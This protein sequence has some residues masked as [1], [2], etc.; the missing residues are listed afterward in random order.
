MRTAVANIME[1][2]QLLSVAHTNLSAAIHQSVRDAREDM[3]EIIGRLDSFC[4]AIGDEI[5]SAVREAL[6]S[7][8][9]QPISD[10]LQSSGLAADKEDA[11]RKLKELQSDAE[12]VRREKAFAEEELLGAV[13]ALSLRESASVARSADSP[14]EFVCPITLAVM[15]DPVLVNE[16]GISYDRRGHWRSCSPITHA[17]SRRPTL[18]MASPCTTRRITHCAISLPHGVAQ[19]GVL[20]VHIHHSSRHHHPSNKQSLLCLSG[21]QAH[22]RHPARADSIIHAKNAHLHAQHS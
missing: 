11:L 2:T 13:C 12:E 5:R 14:D 22:P 18:I 20:R 10:K 15:Q 9:V 6:A 21:S 19:L 17:A 7:D 3:S 1:A 8:C 16:F 4:D